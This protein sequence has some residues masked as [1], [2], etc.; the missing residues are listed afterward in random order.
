MTRMPPRALTAALALLALAVT[1]AACQE[2]EEEPPPGEPTS[3]TGQTTPL[4]STRTSATVPAG[5]NDPDAIPAGKTLW[6]WLNLTV[7]IDDGSGITVVREVAGPGY[8]PPEGGPIMTLRRNGESEV[9]LH[10]ETGQV[11]RQLVSDSDR[12]FLEEAITTICVE[13]ATDMSRLPWPYGQLPPDKAKTERGNLRYW[14]PEP[15]SGIDTAFR[16]GVGVDGEGC[17]VAI[18]NGRSR[19]GIRADSGAIIVEADSIASSDN[20]AFER[21][22]QAVELIKQ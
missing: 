16:C 18:S 7:T 8:F 9:I 22:T 12:V 3:P 5:C 15:A 11:V 1:L 20:A 4:A 14:E 13:D 17:F 10:A 6:R 19:R 2:T 21:W